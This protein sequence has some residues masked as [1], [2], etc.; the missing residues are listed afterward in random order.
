MLFLLLVVFRP[1]K[2]GRPPPSTPAAPAAAPPAPFPLADEPIHP[3]HAELAAQGLHDYTYEKIISHRISLGLPHLA[4]G[5]VTDDGR[6]A[7]RPRFGGGGSPADPSAAAGAGSVEGDPTATERKL[8]EIAVRY[9]IPFED[10]VRD[11]AELGR[12]AVAG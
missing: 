11:M 2:T 1:L 5:G 7:S 9:G 10:L 4:E 6:P 3:S 12:A 8:R